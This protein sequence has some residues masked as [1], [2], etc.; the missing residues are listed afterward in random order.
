MQWR[1]TRLQSMNS[2]QTGSVA[3]VE[4]SQEDWVHI[5]RKYVSAEFTRY[6]HAGQEGRGE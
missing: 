4:S 6:G 2:R 1:R 3:E 5:Y